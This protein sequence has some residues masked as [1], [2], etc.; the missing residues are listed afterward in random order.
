MEMG[1]IA[2]M[3]EKVD[4][5]IRAIKE[6]EGRIF[7]YSDVDVQFFNVIQESILGVIKRKDMAIQQDLCSGS[8]CAGFFACRGNE[9]TL[10]LWEAVRESLCLQSKHNDQDLLNKELL[11]C[12][13]PSTLKWFHALFGQ[14]IGLLFYSYYRLTGVNLA[15]LVVNL[16]GSSDSRKVTWCYLPLPFFSPGI[17]LNR[18][19]KP[20]MTIRLPRNIL[21]HHANWARG[22]ERK[23][24]QLRLVRETVSA[25]VRI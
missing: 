15:P 9:R 23:I 21:M 4:L 24:E 8:L 16:F 22:V 2:T 18:E 17:S 20:G 19:W 1:W 11:A 25:R 7:I 13:I 14:S 5:I 6:N 3:R 10:R 12:G